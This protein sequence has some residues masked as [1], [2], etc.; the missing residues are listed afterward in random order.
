LPQASSDDVDE[1]SAYEG[2]DR[3]QWLRDNVPPHHA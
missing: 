3:D 2:A 1:E